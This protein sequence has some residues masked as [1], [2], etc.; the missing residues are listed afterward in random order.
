MWEGIPPALDNLIDQ[1]LA[2]DPLCRPANSGQLA[3][4]LAPLARD[5][6]LPALGG[7]MAP[8]AAA[9]ETSDDT[10]LAGVGKP[11]RSRGGSWLAIGALAAV[12]L[13]IALAGVITIRFRDDQGK[14]RIVEVA[15]DAL[16][17][18]CE[19]L[20]SRM[21]GAAELAVPLQVEA[22]VGSNWDEAH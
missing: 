21:A 4:Q 10:R 20:C 9:C 6:D 5:A 18:V 19:G 11:H 7:M 16:E 15:D 13:L 22:G 14:E 2:K 17:S 8:L 3:E 1:L 12:P